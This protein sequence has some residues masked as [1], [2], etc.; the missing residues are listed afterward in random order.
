[1]APSKS[2]STQS[3]HDK[4]IDALL[5]RLHTGCR[6]VDFEGDSNSRRKGGDGNGIKIANLLRN[7]SPPD[8]TH[9]ELGRALA[10]SYVGSLRSITSKLSQS[11]SLEDDSVQSAVERGEHIIKSLCCGEDV[12]S[13][14]NSKYQ[15][16]RANYASAGYAFFG[17]LKSFYSSIE[18]EDAPLMAFIQ[19]QWQNWCIQCE[20]YALPTEGI[21]SNNRGGGIHVLNSCL[22]NYGY[23][24]CFGGKGDGCAKVY[25]S[26]KHHS[27]RK[28]L[29][30]ILIEHAFSLSKSKVTWDA[31][32][33]VDIV[34]PLFHSC[35]LSARKT[36]PQSVNYH[37]E[38]QLILHDVL[39]GCS[40]L[41]DH[42]I[43]V[44]SNSASK[45]GEDTHVGSIANI[46][47]YLT[48]SLTSY[49]NQSI[50]AS[51]VKVARDSEDDPCLDI[52]ELGYDWLRG[53]CDL[54][55]KLVSL[56]DESI[57]NNVVSRCIEVIITSILPQYTSAITTNFDMAPIYSTLVSC[58]D[59]LSKRKRPLSMDAKVV[60]RLGSMAL[61]LRD[62]ADVLLVCD[63]IYATFGCNSTNASSV[64]TGGIL[65]TLGCI[66]RC[67]P[68]CFDKATF[69]VQLGNSI[70]Q[71]SGSQ[72]YEKGQVDGKHLMN[73]IV[74]SL[75]SDFFQPLMDIISTSVSD[76]CSTPS[77]LNIWQRRSLCLSDQCSGLLLGL[78]LLHISISPSQTMVKLD[79]AFAFIQTFLVC[80]PRLA[81]RVVP[82]VIDIT[83]T[84]MSSQS[85]TIEPI[86]S[87]AP[88]GFLASPCIVS[89]PHGA[90]LTWTYLSSLIKDTPTPVRST[91][92]RLLPDMCSSNKRLFRRVRDVIGKSIG[93][94]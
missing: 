73:I 90:H 64:F 12:S 6:F 59:L 7:L 74:G 66:F 94:Q 91:V 3:H 19:S 35:V 4:E 45:G 5:N 1:M 13:D 71:S 34:S 30:R 65:V 61:N 17:H 52:F 67:R 26:L 75:G 33:L 77:S 55:T 42:N 29:I 79:D 47:Q 81:S 25:M 46:I 21:Q 85:S 58:V 70:I 87:L 51:F 41:V 83:R 69:L 18:E 22:K 57:V 2:S 92:I 31:T 88:L 78:S 62:E 60:L 36:T 10:H 24:C 82:S 76:V 14:G 40:L 48:T 16:D 27:S 50:Y 84:L 20:E 80:Y 8:E 38:R 53:I 15:P 23:I 68:A 37:A 9:A 44:V 39:R 56:K 63:L 43:M 93:S 11:S 54:M 49:L 89:D 28:C 32:G 86:M 72:K